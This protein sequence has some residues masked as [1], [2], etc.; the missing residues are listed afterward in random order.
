MKIEII[1]AI[2]SAAAGIAGASIA[3]IQAVRTS[4]MKS[5]A[6]AML[7]KIKAEVNITLEKIKAEVNITLERMKETRERRQKAF[8][9]ASQESA[10]VEAALSQAWED[11]QLIKE[12]LTR[13]TSSARYDAD[14]ALEALKP[15][16]QRIREGYAK[17]GAV[18]PETARRA[19]HSAKGSIATLEQTLTIESGSD[20]PRLPESS[21]AVLK[22]MRVFIDDYQD[23]LGEARQGIRDANIKHLMEVI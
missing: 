7:E 5:Q 23:V 14:I 22:D 8:E 18:L 16:A 13:L 6:D 9:I 1:I 12:I 11:I 15:P 3:S 2:I 4:K 21:V 17:W 19:W 10:P 20:D